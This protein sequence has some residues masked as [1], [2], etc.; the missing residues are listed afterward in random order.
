MRDHTS[1][2]ALALALGGFLNPCYADVT[3]AGIEQQ[4]Y[5]VL[6]Q[7][8]MAPDSMPVNDYLLAFAKASN[9]NFIADARDIDPN[10][11]MPEYPAR[12]E[13]RALRNS[14][15]NNYLPMVYSV[16]K[17]FTAACHLAELRYNSKTFLFWDGFDI[18][19]TGRMIVDNGLNLPTAPPPSEAQIYHDLN[20]YASE[21]HGWKE[22]PLPPK[23]LTSEEIAKVMEAS[24]RNADTKDGKFMQNDGGR[25]AKD[26][27]S[28]RTP[29]Y[30]R[31]HL[32]ELPAELQNEVIAHTLHARWKETRDYALWLSDDFWKTARVLQ[33]QSRP[34]DSY[35]K[36][37]GMAPQTPLERTLYIG[38][39]DAKGRATPFYNIAG[40]EVTKLEAS[41]EQQPEIVPAE[42]PIQPNSTS[43]YPVP[44]LV[45]AIAAA[46]PIARY[47]A[48]AALDADPEL[49]G[50]VKLDAIRLPL[51]EVL[52]QAQQQSE[53]KLL[54]AP[55]V[56]GS[57]LLTL[58]TED[59][60][61]GR[62]MG[63]L[64][65]L[66]GMTWQKQPDDSYLLV[67]RAIPPMSS[68]KVKEKL[69]QI[70]LRKGQE[71]TSSN[72]FLP[73]WQELAASD[74]YQSAWTL[75]EV[76]LRAIERD[77]RLR[78]GEGVPFSE[79]PEDLQ[80]GL[81]QD[82]ME[83]AAI[84]IS[85]QFFRNLQLTPESV[86]YIKRMPATTTEDYVSNV[87]SLRQ[88][89]RFAIN[90]ADD[91]STLTPYDA[92]LPMPLDEAQ[93]ALK[94]AEAAAKGQ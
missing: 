64:G 89:L 83:A 70:A 43:P 1:K 60:T 4:P 53:V 80:A 39:T 15:G 84:M 91:K 47:E 61:S 63:A 7:R 87:P 92:I 59:L 68:Q 30:I 42:V 41:G 86:C 12:L 5:P 20:A 11:V 37:I 76:T 69:L 19:D 25:F 13:W 73:N 72:L 77:P 21:V 36:K 58:H 16:M 54:M 82:Y 93:A 71:S 28:T 90:T 23:P 88:Y 81:K 94:L 18:M 27:L 6:K 38:G 35:Y 2:I 34:W 75:E 78:S 9:Y 33:G 46:E 85:A 57:M 55:E 65:R 66:Y 48:Q 62:F 50:Q 52:Q 67:P 40:T 74:N 3:S 8:I 51:R 10:I 79:L 22:L 26:S 17:D 44:D 29:Q 24:K 32:K 56:D 45:A 31:L 49:G 14:K